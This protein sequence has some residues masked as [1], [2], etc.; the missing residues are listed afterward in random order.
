[1]KRFFTALLTAVIIVSLTV[2][3][4]ADGPMEYFYDRSLTAA[5]RADMQ[6][7]RSNYS[8]WEQAKADAEKSPRN[9]RA[10][11][12][13]ER[14]NAENAEILNKYGWRYEN[15]RFYNRNGVLISYLGEAGSAPLGNTV[16]ASL[17]QLTASPTEANQAVVKEI[18]PTSIAIS[19]STLSLTVGNTTNLT[20]TISPSS[21]SNKSVLWFTSNRNVATV[22]STGAIT[23]VGEG[24]AVVS[25][26]TWNGY[27]DSC[28]VSVA[29]P[30]IPG[31]SQES[32]SSNSG[33]SKT[34]TGTTTPGNS[35]DPISNPLPGVNY[36]VTGKSFYY[37]TNSIGTVEYR[38]YVEVTNTGT[39]NLYLKDAL[40]DLEDDDGHLLQSDNFI[41][42]CPDVIAPGE[43]GYFY[44]GISSHTIDES[45][46][47]ANGVN[48]APQIN[49]IKSDSAPVYYEVFDTDLREGTFGNPKVTGRVK[50]NTSKDDS[51]L[52]IEVILYDK[53][54]N[55][56]EIAGTNI[57]GLTAGKTVSFEI[58]AMFLGEKANMSSIASYK[59]SAQKAHYQFR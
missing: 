47:L 43:K 21:A 10:I 1:M 15:G 44:N 19:R 31:N 8:F 48:F 24:L 27:R 59:I 26:E 38:A 3:I 6:R 9:T 14:L 33:G 11:Q 2:P 30:Y 32:T 16:A 18:V 49:V 23:A 41:S 45:V 42:S 17:S 13:R 56:L 4:F 58:N 39:E 52:Y 55:V 5:Q 34:D 28:A 51:L 25:V 35:S 50:N 36:K 20:A 53:N 7:F 29:A 40:F 12:L 22:S 54:G 37:F 57:T 46:S